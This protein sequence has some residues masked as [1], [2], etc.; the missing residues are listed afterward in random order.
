MR[1]ERVSRSDKRAPYHGAFRN[2][3][4]LR[5]ISPRMPRR[6]WMPSSLAIGAVASLALA[7][8]SLALP[9]GPTYDPYAWLIWGRDLA[10]GDLVT[11]AGGTS[12]KP[13]PALIDALLSPLGGG[14]AGGW[15]VVARAG[16]LFAV[17]MAFRLA[18]RLAPRPQRWLA[19]T[20]AAATLLLTHEWVRRNGVADAE[21]LMVAFG[22]LA[23]DRHLDGNRSQAL[24]LIVGAALIRVEPWPYAAAYAAWLFWI[25]RGALRRSAIVLGA[26]TVPLL[27]F[28]GA[29]LGS[30]RLTT[31]SD[32]ALRPLPGTPGASAHPVQAVS[33]EIFQM[34]PLPAWIALVLATLIALARRSRNNSVVLCLVGFAALWMAIVV[35]MTARGYP[36]LPR[37]LFGADGLVAVVAGVGM[38]GSVEVLRR[39]G[40]R[41]TPRRG[42]VARIAATAAAVAAAA[43]FAYGSIPDAQLLPGDAA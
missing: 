7:L 26:L 34:L 41:A 4:A 32:R 39:L 24:A 15:V 28:G 37:F 9:S 18:W 20:V 13:L 31:A 5:A 29:W 3:S 21:G 27:W 12:W 10:H 35:V 8:A 2:S 42:F 38:A 43:A 16:A 11:I 36:G 19:G 6:A 30:G 17:F 23:I 14:A 25:S 40:A 1:A 22:L 33:A